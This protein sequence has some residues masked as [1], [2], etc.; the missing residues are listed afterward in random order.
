MEDYNTRHH[1]NNDVTDGADLFRK[2]SFGAIKR[3]KMWEKIV[4]YIMLLTAIAVIAGVCY[5]YT[6][7]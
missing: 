3:R 5:V 4:F 2:H 1:H 6:A 7:E